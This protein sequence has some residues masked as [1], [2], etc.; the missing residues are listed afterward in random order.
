MIDRSKP[1]EPALRRHVCLAV[2]LGLGLAL[3][4]C[5]TMADMGEATGEGIS[6]AANAMNP[7][8]WFGDKEG[9]EA[10]TAAQPPAAGQDEDRYPKLSTVPERPKDAK[11][12]RAQLE[13]AK[14]KEGLVADTANAQYTDKEL[15]A[16]TGAATPQNRPDLARS[17]ERVTEAPPAQPAPTMPVASAPA[18][19]LAATPAP[20]AAQPAAPRA[21]PPEAARPQEA[22]AA[23]RRQAPAATAAPVTAAAPPTPAQPPSPAPAPAVPERHASLA[24]PAPEKPSAEQPEAV[25]KT[26]QVATIYF[27]D[28]SAHL[29]P[30][31]RRVVEKVAEVARMTGG[32]LRIVGHSSVGPATGDPERRDAVNYKMS[33]ER[34]NAVAEELRRRGVP[35][36]HMQVM[37]EGSRNPIYAETAPTGAAGNRRTEIYLDYKERL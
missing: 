29:S 20:N 15:R 21:A 33:L 17:N 6:T 4:G 22:A 30:Q 10:A 1:G 12:K 2:L 18:A 25:L 26:A 35:A 36:S 24:Q 16:Q 8:N 34:A 37:A 31:D 3:G 5:G 23:T 27:G 28:G 14:L 11:S 32:T 9:E 19:P 13:R 7:F